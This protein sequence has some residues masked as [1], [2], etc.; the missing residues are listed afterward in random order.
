MQRQE[1]GPTATLFDV[2]GTLVDTTVVHALCWHDALR[3]NDHIVPMAQVHRAIGM[4]SSELLDHLL[5]KRRDPD[6]DEVISTAHRVLYRQ[7][8]ERLLPFPGAVELIRSC[9]RRGQRIVLASS[10]KPDELDMLRTSLD[11]EDVIHGATCSDDVDAA[12]PADDL[13]QVALEKADADPDDAVFV[14][15]AVWDGIAAGKAGVRFIGVSCGAASEPE[16]REAGAV[17]VWADPAE[18]LANLEQSLLGS[19]ANRR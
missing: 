17:E 19:R 13:I 11:V 5:G 7:H 4:G 15:D 10:A 16:L 6:Q 3:A 14:G 12:K 18:L 2:D 9:A 8:W 1:A